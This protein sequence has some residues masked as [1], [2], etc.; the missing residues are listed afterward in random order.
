M[1]G[2]FSDSVVQRS[3]GSSIFRYWKSRLW[4]LE[5]VVA[6]S[7]DSYAPLIALGRPGEQVGAGRVLTTEESWKATFEKLAGG[8]S[9]IFLIPSSHPGTLW[10]LRR[11]V[12]DPEMLRKT[13]FI[14]PPYYVK[15]ERGR[16]LEDDAFSTFADVVNISVQDLRKM[17]ADYP[18][19]THTKALRSVGMIF[20]WSSLGVTWSE[21]MFIRM[22]PPIPTFLADLFLGRETT[23]WS[24]AHLRL[25]VQR[26]VRD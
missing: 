20:R 21:P 22:F 4:D 14:I 17:F 24:P 13:A 2:V 1:I 26:A 7:V 12:V 6:M 11:V 3:N 16:A 15:D 25:V 23:V 18:R 8:V 5:T 19:A 9:T 10:E